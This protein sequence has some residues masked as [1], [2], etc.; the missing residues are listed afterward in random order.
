MGRKEGKKTE[1]ITRKREQEMRKREVA[2]G[3]GREGGV[4]G[5]KAVF[6]YT[7]EK[8]VMATMCK[9]SSR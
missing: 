7:E 3:R 5:R 2:G 8:S 1:A 6:R 4:G 9:L